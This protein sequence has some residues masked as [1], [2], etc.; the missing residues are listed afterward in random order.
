MMFD[1]WNER[2]KKLSVWDIGLIKWAVFCAT[3][4]VVKLIPSLLDIN[5][6][7]FVLFLIVFSVKPLYVFWVKK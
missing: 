1:D 4:V 3:I 2:V 5:I 6:W 7:V